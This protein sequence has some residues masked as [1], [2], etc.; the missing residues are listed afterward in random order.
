MFTCICIN[1]IFYNQCW[2]KKGLNKLP[3]VYTDSSIKLTFRSN[4]NNNKEFFT[5]NISFKILLNMFNKKQE[6]EFDVVE[7]EGFCENPGIWIN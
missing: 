4:S 1:C 5:R 3:K 6:Y 2:I 7:C